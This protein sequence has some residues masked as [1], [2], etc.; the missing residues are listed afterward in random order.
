MRPYWAVGLDKTQG[1]AG[2]MR[3]FLDIRK[4]G[5]RAHSWV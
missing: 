4:K 5:V 3:L 1:L 2:S